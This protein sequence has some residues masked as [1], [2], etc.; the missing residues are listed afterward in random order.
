MLEVGKDVAA[1]RRVLDEYKMVMQGEVWLDK[2]QG[3]GVMEVVVVENCL[4]PVDCLESGQQIQYLEKKR[5]EE[6]R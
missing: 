4:L 3:Y 6:S 5:T 1:T 2:A